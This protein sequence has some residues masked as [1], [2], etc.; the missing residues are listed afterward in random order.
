MFKKKAFFTALALVGFSFGASAAV[1]T[2]TGSV[3]EGPNG[4]SEIDFYSFNVTA[5]GTVTFTVD[6]QGIGFMGSDLDSFLV[7]AVDDGD[8]SEDDVIATNDDG[9]PGFD[10]FLSIV[11][12]VGSYLVGVSSCCISPS[13]FVA[14]ENLSIGFND[15][16]PVYQLTIDG[17]VSTAA[18]V[19]AP[20][21]LALVS[22]GL[23]GAAFAR[24]RKAA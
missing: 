7:L 3:D 13:E 8:R 5:L 24:R 21:S 12:D 22:I 23:L 2:E 17:N 19:P 14:G 16:N 1:I 18:A 15:T 4:S 9:G 6:A 11:L 20:A 10:S